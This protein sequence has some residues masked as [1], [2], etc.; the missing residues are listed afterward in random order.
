[1]GSI[2]GRLHLELVASRNLAESV[3][4]V[5]SEF[6][7]AFDGSH[8]SQRPCASGPIDSLVEIRQVQYNS[9][10]WFMIVLV[11]YWIPTGFRLD[12]YWIP[13]GFLLD[14]YRIII[15]FL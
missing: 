11:Y 14:P 13:I 15:G 5:S 8:D 12:S 3:M 9:K 2:I 6:V 7:I 4:K 10:Q 1:M